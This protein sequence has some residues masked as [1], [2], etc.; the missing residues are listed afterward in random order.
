MLNLDYFMLTCYNVFSSIHEFLAVAK[1][2]KMN[3]IV[4]LI[5]SGE[6]TVEDL[7]NAPQ[8]IENAKLAR[9]GLEACKKTLHFPFG[10]STIKWSGPWNEDEDFSDG[11]AEIKY[12]S[13]ITFFSSAAPLGTLDLSDSKGIFLALCDCEQDHLRTLL[14]HFLNEHISKAKKK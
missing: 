4:K 13:S 1:E 3:N 11:W 14:Y 7:S 5:E 8:V 9:Q 12:P 2:E 10:Q 6:I